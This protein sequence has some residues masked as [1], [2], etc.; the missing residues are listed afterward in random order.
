M[1]SES[2]RQ[3]RAA[4]SGG[5]KKLAI[6]ALLGREMTDEELREYRKAAAIYDYNMNKKR[7]E[8]KFERLSVTDRS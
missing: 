1:E 3:I 4:A 5:L 2:I 8:R 6:E 7:M